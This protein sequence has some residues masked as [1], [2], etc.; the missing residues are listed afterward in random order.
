MIGWIL[1]GLLGLVFLILLVLTL[2]IGYACD[3]AKGGGSFV[4]TLAGGLYRKRLVYPVKEKG[5]ASAKPAEETKE[6]APAEAVKKEEPIRLTADGYPEKAPCEAEETKADEAGS[7]R[8]EEAE[9]A[10][11]GPG[12]WALFCH[13]VDN[14]AVGIVLC[15]LWKI[16]CHSSPGEISF[17]GRMGTGDPMRT[18]VLAGV[19]YAVFPSVSRITWDYTEKVTDAAFHMKGRIVPLYIIYIAIETALA[20]PVRSVLAMKRRNHHGRRSKKETV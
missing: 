20:R 9:E 7:G 3:A 12:N 16:L 18:G 1:L 2:P 15:A 8:N 10:D 14:G 17:T 6:K 5:N 13:A 11:E 19:M 4:I